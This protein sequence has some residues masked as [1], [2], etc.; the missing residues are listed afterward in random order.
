[1][2]ASALNRACFIALSGFLTVVSCATIPNFVISPYV[3]GYINATDIPMSQLEIERF[4]GFPIPITASDIHF[5]SHTGIDK[6][7]YI[8]FDIPPNDLQAF[9]FGISSSIKLKSNYSPL[10]HIEFDVDW[11][12][13]NSA[14]TYSGVQ[15]YPGGM[16]YDIL[17]D[18]DSDAI[19]VV[20]ITI[21]TAP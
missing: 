17:V 9:L 16:V 19:S 14:K 7:I 8:R 1:M 4:A 11:W 12:N 13:P 15:Y 6:T 10:K 20:Y 18:H 3:E 5:S 21:N 2:K